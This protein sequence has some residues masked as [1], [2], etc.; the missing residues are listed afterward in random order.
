[1]SRA[2][3]TLRSCARVPAG[4]G[5]LDKKELAAA[6]QAAGLP[7]TEDAIQHSMSILDA[8]HDGRISLPE[9]QAMASQNMM[10]SLAEMSMNDNG[11]IFEDF[12]EAY[13]GTSI[14]DKKLAASD[15]KR[16]CADR[17]LA[18][19]HCEVLEDFLDMATSQVQQFCEHC[20]GE[21]ECTLQYV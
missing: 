17:C 4:N 6:F 1:M 2:R 11:H 9:F 15:P 19:G 3:P 10:P 5:F 12:V 21:D 8:D 14:R 18:T 20:A 7:A 13:T 16:Y